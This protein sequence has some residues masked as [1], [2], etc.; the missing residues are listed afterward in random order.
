MGPSFVTEKDGKCT[1]ISFRRCLSV[2]NSE[3]RFAPKFDENDVRTEECTT[4]LFCIG[5][6]VDWKDL[7][8]DTA[9]TFTKRGFAEA[10]SF[11]YQTAEKDIFVGGDCYTGQ[12]FVIDAIAA[13]KEAAMSLHR[14][15][16]PNSDLT[17]GRN[18]RD[19]HEL[20][21]SNYRYNEETFDN[22]PRQRIGY[23]DALRRTFKDARIAFTEEQVKKETA[24]CLSCG[25]SVVDP[26]KCIGCGVCTTKCAFDA[27]HLH[28]ERPECSKM[29]KFEDRGKNIL[30]YVVKKA[31][32]LAKN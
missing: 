11:T 32:H 22:T 18:R 5:Q 2:K 10:D 27:I 7:L 25:Q 16:Q 30:P 28:R 14:F 1:G 24:R 29:S 3:G 19:F 31:L 23:N 6:K 13:G 8:Q 21:K 9:V 26:N 15:V 12:K 20:D 4:I 17:V